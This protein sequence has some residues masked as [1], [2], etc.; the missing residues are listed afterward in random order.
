MKHANKLVVAFAVALSA[1]AFASQVSAQDSKARD[2]AISKCVK[3]AQTQYPDDSITNQQSR[4]DV[5]KACM[6]TAGFA[7]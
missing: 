5:Y 6:S 3:Q 2:A 4:S 7:P 1:A